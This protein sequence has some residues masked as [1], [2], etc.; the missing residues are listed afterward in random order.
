[1]PQ[2]LAATPHIINTV[3]PDE[4][5]GLMGELEVPARG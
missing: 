5:W 2:W 3:V 1:M 4:D